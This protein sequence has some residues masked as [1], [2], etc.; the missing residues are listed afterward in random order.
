[1]SK[2]EYDLKVRLLEK[3][4]KD[5]K[6]E[7]AKEYALANNP[8]K[9]GD[10]ITDHYH[11]IKV[12]R[13]GTAIVIGSPYPACVYSGVQL[14]KDGTPRVNQDDTRMYQDNIKQ[15]VKGQ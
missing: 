6:L 9:V 12:E 5:K 15:V 11:T 7:L 10:I 8:I 1:M 13:I 2:E 14:K 4:L 3:E